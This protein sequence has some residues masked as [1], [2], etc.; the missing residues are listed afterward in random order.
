MPPAKACIAYGIVVLAVSGP[1]LHAETT[2]DGVYTGKRVLTKGSGPAC[3][4]EENVS[5]TISGETLRFTDGSLR[6][7]V[8]AFHPHQDGSF[9][10]IHA[11]IGGD[12]VLI[13][14]RIAGDALEA[15]VTN[16]ACEHHWHLKKG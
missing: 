7:F 9:S 5:V 2:F 13:Q 8:L 4:T 1:A 16:R 10:Q 15:D 14:G 11:D 6:S 12:S 3:P